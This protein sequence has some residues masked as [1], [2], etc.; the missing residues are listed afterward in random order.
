MFYCLLAILVYY[1]LSLLVKI[2]PC[3]T[4]DGHP[5]NF[6]LPLNPMFELAPFAC[7]ERGQ[8]RLGFGVIKKLV[9]VQTIF[10]NKIRFKWFHAPSV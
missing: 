5:Y 6:F 7:R 10:R 2:D 3:D 4:L 8:V 1:P 9:K